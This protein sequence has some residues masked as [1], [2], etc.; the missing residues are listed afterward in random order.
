MAS[1]TDALLKEVALTEAALAEEQE[2]MARDAQ[3]KEEAQQAAAAASAAA[4]EAAA[5]SFRVATPS[6][7]LKAS[8]SAPVI[9]VDAGEF[10][11][12]IHIQSKV[13]YD[14]GQKRPLGSGVP[15]STLSLPKVV[16]KADAALVGSASVQSLRSTSKRHH[17]GNAPLWDFKGQSTRDSRAKL[18]ISNKHTITTDYGKNTN[19]GYRYE[20]LPPLGKRRPDKGNAPMWGFGKADRF[21]Y[22]Y[23]KPEKRPGPEEYS[24]PTSFGSKPH[25]TSSSLPRFG[26][27]SPCTRETARK[28]FVAEKHQ[29]ADLVCKISPGPARYSLPSNVGGKQP[30][31][32]MKDP[33]VYSLGGRIRD[34]HAVQRSP[35][36]IYPVPRA[37]GKQPDIPSAPTYSMGGPNRMPDAVD[38]SPG[39]I[40]DPPS[41]VSKQASST[42]HSAPRPSF[43]KADRWAAH[44][45]ELRKNTVPGPGAYG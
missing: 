2:A 17:Y 14:P 12:H 8:A 21:L 45:A 15:E 5:A 9:G 19:F 3:A 6:A 39:P 38:I 24:L 20:P 11:G 30:D 1:A 41:A 43:T 27:A 32:R 37:I 33:P 36:A 16:N 7:E 34:V 31:G 22:G 4:Q 10:E 40:Y 35:G 23:G 42:K 26:M 13:P 18:F 44:N 25:P 28:I 29:R